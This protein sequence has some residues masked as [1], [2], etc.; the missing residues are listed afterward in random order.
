MSL[1]NKKVL[2]VG[3]G[4]SGQA[5]LRYLLSQG[6]RPAV[7]DLRSAKTLAEPMKSFL[8]FPVDW[9]LGSHEEAVFTSADLIVVS[10]GVPLNLEPLKK[11]RQKGIPVV[12][13]MELAFSHFLLPTS[14]F[15][16]IA[17]TG[18]NGK[19]TTVSLIHHFLKTAGKKSVLAGN[20][21]TPLLDCLEAIKDAEFLVLEIS[22][23]QL[24]TTPS[25]KPAVAVWLNVTE[26]HLH[27]HEGFEGYVNAKTKLI[28][29]TAPKGLV[30]YNAE[31]PIVA[32]CVEQIPSPRLAFSS[33]RQVKLGGWV[34]EGSLL[35]KTGLKREILRFDL[36][37]VALKGITGWENMLAALLALS[38]Y[39]KDEKILQKGLE[40]FMPLPHRLQKVRE[41][42]GVSY[43][44]DSKAT[45]VGAAVKGLAGVGGRVLWI[46]GGRDKGGSYA[47][48]KEWIKKKVR[49]AYLL[50]EAKNKM[51]EEFGALTEIIMVKDLEEAVLLATKEAKSGETILFS[52]ACSSFDMFKDYEERGE[53]FMEYVR[54]LQ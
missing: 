52:P 20:V 17:V 32:Q 38:P 2:I 49:K 6:T 21:G 9:F 33:K 54:G 50:G 16:V 46:A 4:K 5:A 24:E 27:W 12:S 23:Y 29:Q 26:D 28:R 47:P 44:N 30:I 15:H 45:N 42:G 13:E 22:S 18:T 53:K 40:S 25:L 39:I 51:A 11:A 10:P 36:A 8:G 48:L 34:E 35:L 7:T 3:F 43:I 37:H 1:K 14:Y 41:V 19:T 31:D